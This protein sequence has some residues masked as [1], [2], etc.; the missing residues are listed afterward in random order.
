MN[1]LEFIIDF[2]VFFGILLVMPSLRYV[3]GSAGVLPDQRRLVPSQLVW[4][5]VLTAALFQFVLNFSTDLF[6]VFWFICDVR[7]VF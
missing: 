1:F 3:A 6:S 2:T 7:E 4:G 5:T